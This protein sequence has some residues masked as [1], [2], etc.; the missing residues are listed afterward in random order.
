MKL[1]IAPDTS[2]FMSLMKANFNKK[3]EV[4]EPQKN[5]P[6]FDSTGD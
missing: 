1:S 3:Y 6:H 2:F 5:N 4:D